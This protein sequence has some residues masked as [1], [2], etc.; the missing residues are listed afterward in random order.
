ML[1]DL[2]KEMNFKV[3]TNVPGIESG[4]VDKKNVILPLT[5][6]ELVNAPKHG[7]NKWRRC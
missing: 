5:V 2:K 6:S 7:T 3:K 1:H 4:A